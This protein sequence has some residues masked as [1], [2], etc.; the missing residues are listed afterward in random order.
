MIIKFDARLYTKQSIEAAMAAFQD[1]ASFQLTEASGELTVKVSSE[2]AAPDQE[3]E[4]EFA[5]YALSEMS[6]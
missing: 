5:N 4:G 2:G 1:V 3:L 6:K